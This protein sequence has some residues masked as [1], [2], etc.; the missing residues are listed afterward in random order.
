MNAAVLLALVATL[1]QAAHKAPVKVT[2]ETPTSPKV[3]A[4]PALSVPTLG[5]GSPLAPLASPTLGSAQAPVPTL[6]ASVVAPEAAF[7]EQRQ[8]REASA[9]SAP[10]ARAV[11]AQAPAAPAAE[12]APAPTT[13]AGRIKAAMSRIAAALTPAKVE[14]H[15]DALEPGTELSHKAGRALLV[16]A[17]SDEVTVAVERKGEWKKETLSRRKARQAQPGAKADEATLAK[18]AAEAKLDWAHARRRKQDREGYQAFLA[19]DHWSKVKETF[20]AELAKA[21]ALGGK[22]ATS[23]YVRAEADKLV[24]RL[25]AAYGT[26]NIG[27]HYNLHGGARDQYVEGG[28]IRA[29][30]GDI[31]L[32][33]TMNGD[34][35][36]KVY[37]F[38]SAQHSLYDVLDERNP[39]PM[40][41]RMGSVLMLFRLDSDF[42]KQGKASG[43]LYNHGAISMDFDTSRAWGIPYSTFLAPP[44]DVFNGVAKKAGA[45]GLSRDEETLA[46]V[47]YIEAALLGG[48]SQP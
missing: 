48:R 4:A 18:A 26:E 39:Q 9:P 25:K 14:D 3:G 24:E 6:P 44:L 23:A 31:A 16:H 1:A 38:Q 33:Y 42:V 36:Y 43:A 22:A 29:T 21:R 30:M 13:L 47:R 5:G 35:N 15:L 17:G 32:N 37:F 19:A 46:V 27:F 41:S 34:R 11:E 8:G 10:L 7:A 12:A 20:P 40:I 45:K 2:L 28:G